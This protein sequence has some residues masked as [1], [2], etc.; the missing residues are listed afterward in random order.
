[1]SRADNESLLAMQS[2]RMSVA[3]IAH[4]MGWSEARVQ[5]RL[6]ALNAPRS[7]DQPVPANEAD[8]QLGAPSADPAPPQLAAGEGWVM[9]T[10]CVFAGGYGAA[11]VIPDGRLV[12]AETGRD[13]LPLSVK[14]AV[15]QS[16]DVWTARK[17][18]EAA[19]AA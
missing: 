14:V 19:R 5:R 2:A 1:M 17:L 10:F 13:Q 6:E 12:Y 18:K 16:G 4:T 9:W 15:V 8:D 3:S 11:V 7:P